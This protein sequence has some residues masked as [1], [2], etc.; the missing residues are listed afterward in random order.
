MPL[1]C[2]ALDQPIRL[3]LSRVFQEGAD[4]LARIFWFVVT[5][6][7]TGDGTFS[8]RLELNH[9]KA[10]GVWV[11]NHDSHVFHRTHAALQG[12]SIETTSRFFLHLP[13]T[14]PMA[15]SLG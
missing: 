11:M 13:R 9:D 10:N 1:I 8:I 3:A 6:P 12:D 14:L 2:R 4:F 5:A 7:R 15:S